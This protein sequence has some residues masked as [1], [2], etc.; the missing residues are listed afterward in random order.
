MQWLAK[1]DLSH[2]DRGA[3]TMGMSGLVV[4]GDLPGAAVGNDGANRLDA[5]IQ[6][7][8]LAAFDRQP[9]AADDAR[10]PAPDRRYRGCVGVVDQVPRDVQ[11]ALGVQRLI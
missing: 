5:A 11:Q 2:P 3:K 7:V 6:Q 9:S 10:S 8:D 1:G 4:H